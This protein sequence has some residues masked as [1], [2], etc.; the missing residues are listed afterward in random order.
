MYLELGCRALIAALAGALAVVAPATAAHAAAGCEVTYTM[1]PWPTPGFLASVQLRNTGDQPWNGYTVDFR[2][3]GNQTV[4]GLW[5]QTW[6]QAGQSV[7][8]RS[9]TWESPVQPGQA[10]YLG[11]TASYYGT[12]N[13]P[14][15]WRVNG[16]PCSTPDAPAVVADRNYVDVLEG[17]GQGFSVRLSHPPSGWAML[18]MSSSG[19]GVWATPPSIVYFS[20]ADWNYRL[21]T[22]MSAQDAD[23]VD[24][25]VV[26]TLSVDGYAP[27][28]VTFQQIDD[29]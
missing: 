14:I 7:T 20:P 10:A 28:T 8:A 3:T 25:R 17:T 21:I 11:F 23:T 4:T 2:F 12:N 22:V 5:H 6:S 1:Q 24:D 18:H 15:D 26:F 13:P 19:T 29:D 16:V 9:A 27:T